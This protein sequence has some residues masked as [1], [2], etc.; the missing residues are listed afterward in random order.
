M[1]KS[2]ANTIPLFATREEIQKAVM[3]IVTD[4]G[5][6]EAGGIPANVYAI[7]KL[8]RSESD[9]KPIY[10]ANKGRYKAL[11]EA[12]INDIDAFI[13]PMRERREKLARDPKKVMKILDKGG[14]AAK[15]IADKKLEAVKKA[16]GVL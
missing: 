6:P 12:L 5:G 3:S 9:L 11:K 7:H 16:I 8:F 4:S 15:K 13:K 1:S 14:V 2:Y 10:E